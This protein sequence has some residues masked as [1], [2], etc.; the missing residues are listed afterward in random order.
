MTQEFS[1]IVHTYTLAEISTSDD[2]NHALHAIADYISHP[3][4]LNY[5]SA[6]SATNRVLYSVVEA[7]QNVYDIT[8]TDFT[9]LDSFL[10]STENYNPYHLLFYAQGYISNEPPFS[11]TYDSSLQNDYISVF[12]TLDVLLEQ[13]REGGIPDENILT[14][15]EVIQDMHQK[16]DL[17]SDRFDYLR[18]DY[19]SNSSFE[20]VTALAES[21]TTSAHSFCRIIATYPTELQ[22][23]IND[24]INALLDP[25][26]NGYMHIPISV[27]SN[28]M[29]PSWLLKNGESHYVYMDPVSL[30]VRTN[31][32]DPEDAK[33]AEFPFAWYTVCYDIS[34]EDFLSYIDMLHDSEIRYRGYD[35]DDALQIVAYFPE[36]TLTMNWT[37]LRT[38][39]ILTESHNPAQ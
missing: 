1:E 27:P 35:L 34:R 23:Q 8:R 15:L 2:I 31:L 12:C 19:E 20:D 29:A 9:R 16:R 32:Y 24:R 39:L 38:V 36:L 10:L 13:H 26:S 17:L 3:D 21:L 11:S 5:Q 18:W 28:W 4:D 33:S 37:E 30:E 25:E 14:L 6:R 7:Y 22:L